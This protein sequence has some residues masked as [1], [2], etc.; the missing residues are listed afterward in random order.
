MGDSKFSLAFEH[1]GEKLA[2]SLETAIDS[3]SVA[4]HGDDI[5]VMQINFDQAKVESAINRLAEAAK[6]LA[7]R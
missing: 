4:L 1:A 5:G 7:K 6:E 2:V 3:D